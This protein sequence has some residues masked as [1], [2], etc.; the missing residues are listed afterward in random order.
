MFSFAPHGHHHRIDTRF[1][2]IRVVNHRGL[3]AVRGVTDVSDELGIAID[4][5]LKTCLLKNIQPT[6]LI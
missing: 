3:E 1:F 6:P 5:E 2:K 4:H